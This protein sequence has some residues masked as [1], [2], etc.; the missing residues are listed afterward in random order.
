M[1]DPADIP[2]YPSFNDDLSGRPLRH[3]FHREISHLSSQSWPDWSD[4]QRILARAYAQG[5]QTDA[6]VGDVL[7]T[8]D[9]LE[10]TDNTIVIW[11]ADHGD[12]VAAHGGLW[13]KSNSFMGRSCARSLRHPLASW[14]RAR[15]AHRRPRFQH[16]RDCHH[17]GRRWDC[18]ARLHAQPQPAATLRRRF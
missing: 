4:W 6:A 12:A 3:F 17:A 9:E 1:V 18:R 7:D 15:A 14:H 5:L 2:E 11:L 8:L 16:G 10:L 13:D